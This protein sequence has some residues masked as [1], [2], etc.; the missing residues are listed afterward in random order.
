MKFMT[1]IDDVTFMSTNCKHAQV[2]CFLEILLVLPLIDA[3]HDFQL[4][5]DLNSGKPEEVRA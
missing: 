5:V 1:S 2:F 3:I 4:L